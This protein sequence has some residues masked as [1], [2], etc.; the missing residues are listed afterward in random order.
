MKKIYI[1]VCLL[2]S[3]ISISFA[4]PGANIN[5][6]RYVFLPDPEEFLTGFLPV[7][8]VKLTVPQAQ[9]LNDEIYIFNNGAASTIRM[10]DEPNAQMYRIGNNLLNIYMYNDSLRWIIEQSIIPTVSEG[11]SSGDPMTVIDVAKYKRDIPVSNI[12][13]L[14]SFVYYSA[15]AQYPEIR[16]TYHSRLVSNSSIDLMLFYKSSQNFV[17]ILGFD[18]SYRYQIHISIDFKSTNRQ[19]AINQINWI[20]DNLVFSTELPDF[21]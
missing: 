2:I 18:K 15:G 21:F 9:Q 1:T 8:A 7:G 11:P 13:K 10:D 14:Q 4:Q 16:S 17:S 20:A 3:M 6:Y 5:D 19:E 12:H